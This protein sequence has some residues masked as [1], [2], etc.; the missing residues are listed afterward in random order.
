MKIDWLFLRCIQT[1]NTKIPL[2]CRFVH[3]FELNW[4]S[5]R[6]IK[7]LYSFMHA[8]TLTPSERMLWTCLIQ[9]LPFSKLPRVLF[10]GVLEWNAVESWFW[11]GGANRG[12]I[13]SSGGKNVV[14]VRE[15]T[16]A[17]RHHSAY[18]MQRKWK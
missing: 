2:S 12:E 7:Y 3:T 14:P 17:F 8:H 10:P 16:S 5:K 9:S 13:P 15:C 4:E 18:S 11:V 1:L 6:N